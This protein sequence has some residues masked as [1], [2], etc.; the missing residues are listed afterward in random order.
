MAETFDL[1]VIGTGSAA[2]TVA[3][4][5]RRAGWRVAVVDS[6]PFGGTCALR[7]CDPKKVLV[8]AAEAEER[9]RDLDGRGLRRDGARIEW[10]DLMRFKRTFTAPVPKAREEGFATA[11]IAAYH[12]RARFVGPSS[13]TVGEA[14]LEAR[15]VVIA[16]GARPADLGIPGA[17]LAITSDQF[18]ELD[19]LPPRLVFLGGGYVSFELAHVAAR[20][21]AKAT[22]LHRGA[23]P[24]AGFDPDLVQMLVR[25]S[26]EMG[27]DVGLGAEVTAIEKQAGGYRVRT[28]ADPDTVAT[29]MVVHGAGRI[30]EIDDLGLEVAG[31]EWGRRGVKVN[32][33]L[34]SVS[35]PAVYAAGDAA[36]SGPPLTPVAGLEGEIVAR[37]LLD[38][39]RHRP[40]YSGVASVVF[41]VPPLAAVGM[42]E[43]EAR[44]SGLKVRALHQDTSGWYSSRRIGETCSGFKTI[45]EEPTGRIL[46]AH[47]L[48]HG[49]DELVNLFALAIRQKL[50]AAALKEVPYAYPTLASN[51]RYML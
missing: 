41:T 28:A 23:R 13:V 24:L 10:A 18:L 21:G 26:R 19:R 27:I 5:C 17:A 34:Q 48:G 49:A 3:G 12:G 6:R 9:I 1:V 44:R 31:V 43:E 15:N 30:A 2:S 4:E 39:H 35:N 7:G 16:A 22:I 14:R 46:G 50:N 42:Q 37:N 33:F 8:G 40:D 51:V 36:D 25:R 38:G 29:D 45:V 11:G 32:E 20:A 47:L